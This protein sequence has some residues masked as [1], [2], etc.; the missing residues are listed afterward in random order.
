MPIYD[1]TC[2]D[3]GHTEEHLQRHADTEMVPCPEGCRAFMERQFPD[4]GRVTVI[5]GT[6]KFQRDVRRT[7]KTQVSIKTGPEPGEGGDGV[8]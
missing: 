1:Y 8:S 5:G 4:P 6:P 3:C 7:R 2:P